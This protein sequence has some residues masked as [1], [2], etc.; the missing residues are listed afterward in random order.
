MTPFR[1]ANRIPER[2]SPGRFDFLLASHQIF[3]ICVILAAL[4]H[5]QSVLTCLHYRMSQPICERQGT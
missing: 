2:L 1:S 4:A 3:H 5:Y